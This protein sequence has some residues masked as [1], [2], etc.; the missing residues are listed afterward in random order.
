M[1]P[2]AR[3]TA[4]RA[5]TPRSSRSPSSACSSRAPTW[6]LTRA[7]R[8]RGTADSAVRGAATT[9]QT[10][11]TATTA[12]RRSRSSKSLPARRSSA[13]CRPPRSSSTRHRLARRTTTGL[14]PCA[15]ARRGKDH[16]LF[17]CPTTLGIRGVRVRDRDWFS[18][19]KE[20]AGA[21]TSRTEAAPLRRHH[22]RTAD[23]AAQRAA[24]PVS[25]QFALRC[26]CA[27]SEWRLYTDP[28]LRRAGPDVAAHRSPPGA[29]CVVATASGDA[30][31]R[32]SP[33]G[34]DAR[35]G[36][37]LSHGRVFRLRH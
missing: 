21:T 7:R 3:P 13:S 12:A 2:R 22:G 19:A 36:G 23:T 5:R 29:R 32:G 26:W 20:E 16:R 25:I 33:G 11:T 9:T 35:R 27:L 18:K 34:L 14:S 4:T 6:R 37:D 1:C 30:G 8:A 10:A 15:A 31:A 28:A 17:R 24:A